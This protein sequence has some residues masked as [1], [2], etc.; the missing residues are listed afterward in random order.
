M[1]VIL[2]RAMNAAVTSLGAV[3]PVVPNSMVDSTLLFFYYFLELEIH[4]GR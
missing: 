1:L 2:A 3:V 4:N